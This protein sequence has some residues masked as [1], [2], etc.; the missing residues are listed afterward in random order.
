[1]PNVLMLD[2]GFMS[3]AHCARGLAAA[4]LRVTVLAAIGGHGRCE[5]QG[6]RWRVT[7]RLE[8]PE[9]LE[10]VIAMAGAEA[11]VIYPVTEP[12]RALSWKLPGPLAGRVFPRTSPRHRALFADKRAMATFVSRRGVPIPSQVDARDRDALGYPCVIKGLNGRGGCATHI[13]PSA[14]A[15]ASVVARL[16]DDRCFAQEYVDGAT[17]IVG[18]LFDRGRALRAYAARKV[19]QHPARV[20]PASHL[21]TVDEPALL[22]AALRMFCALRISG[23]ASADFIRRPNGEFAFLEINPRPWGSIGAVADAGVDLF[24]PFAELLHGR[25]P[26]PDLS[27][28]VGVASSVFPLYL[29]S[30]DEWRHPRLLMHRVVHDLGSPSGRIWRQAA[31]LGHRLIRVAH[32]WPQL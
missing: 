24:S 7:D 19:M 6:V 21:E 32:N 18:G 13:V 10:R 26:S 8:S 23:L 30:R 2:E 17:Y 27:Y 14:A 4:G 31:H 22:V 9:E 15:A 1:M 3:G 5:A 29:A 28:A 20:G 25:T 12:L 16:G 11:D